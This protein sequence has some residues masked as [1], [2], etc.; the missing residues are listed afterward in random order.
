M[1]VNEKTFFRSLR[2]DIFAYML[3]HLRQRRFS[4]SVYAADRPFLISVQRQKG[5]ARE[6]IMHMFGDRWQ[7]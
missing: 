3:T 5:G 2:T 6:W 1:D 4:H 7:L